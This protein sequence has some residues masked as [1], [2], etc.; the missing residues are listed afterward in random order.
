MLIH[1]VKLTDELRFRTI[2]FWVFALEER[3]ARWKK[4]LTPGGNESGLLRLLIFHRVP[5]DYEQNQ[6][7]GR[8]QLPSHHGN[9]FVLETFDNHESVSRVRH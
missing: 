4:A 1:V 6:D 9:I 3:H 7:I 5:G 2:T 8:V